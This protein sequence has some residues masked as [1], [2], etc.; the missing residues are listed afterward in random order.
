MEITVGGGPTTYPDT[1]TGLGDLPSFNHK[2][3]PI[4]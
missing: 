2:H 3:E 1:Q 4:I